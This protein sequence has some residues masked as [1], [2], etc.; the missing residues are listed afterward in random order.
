L[1]LSYN[2]ITNI[3]QGFQNYIPIYSRS[4]SEIPHV[5]LVLQNKIQILHLPLWFCIYGPK[6][7]VENI[8]HVPFSQ[9]PIPI[10]N[11]C[12]TNQ[13]TEDTQPAASSLSMEQKAARTPTHTDQ[14]EAQ[15][16][17]YHSE[18]DS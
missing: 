10:A 14:T 16:G 13:Y 8:L 2:K 15:W 3:Y 4:G 5:C 6:L 18:R 12:R 1:L 9:S 17:C 11:I 7:D